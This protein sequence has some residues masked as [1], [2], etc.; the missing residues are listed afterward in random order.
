MDMDGTIFRFVLSQAI[1]LLYLLILTPIKESRWRSI[2]AILLGTFVIA[3]INIVIINYIG[4]P[5][6]TRFYILTLTLPCFIVFSFY[7][8][9]KGKKLLF[10]F[11]TYQVIGNVAIINGLFASYFFYGQNNPLIDGIARIITYVI[12]LP[13]L[14]KVI[15]PMYLKMLKMLNQGW[16][17]LNSA[18]ILAYALAYYILFVPNTIF[19]RPEYFVHAYLGILLSFLIYAIIYFLFIEVQSKYIIE[20]DKQRLFNQ[21]T[22]LSAESEV[23]SSIAYKDS[24]TGIYNRHSLYKQMDQLTWNKQN[25]LVVFIDLDN[26]KE[27]ND[28]YDHS[29]GDEYLKQFALAVQRTIKENGKV[30]RFAGDEFVCIITNDSMKFN[31]DSF[32]D[33]IAKEMTIDVPFLGLSLGLAYFPKDGMTPDEL[34]SFADQAMYS[35]KRSK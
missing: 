28:T 16:W 15:R 6:Y 23:I 33:C 2:L 24:L 10:S 14:I 5:F 18:L 31:N 22:S 11:L 21:I 19:H 3:M 4:V 17:I 34:I 13:I 9:Y 25:F 20:R 27:I 26:L 35:E 30:Y 1:G 12:F 8:I 7:A 29:K 32:K